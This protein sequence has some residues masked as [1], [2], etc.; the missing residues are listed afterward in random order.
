M[1]SGTVM[2]TD[3]SNSGAKGTL[4]GTFRSI[5]DIDQSGP[6]YALTNGKF[7]AGF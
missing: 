1:E 4:S 3:F 2:V 7:E 6:I 5:A